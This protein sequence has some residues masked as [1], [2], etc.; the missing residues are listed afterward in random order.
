MSSVTRLFTALTPS[1]R[2]FQPESELRDAMK[3][4][5]AGGASAKPPARL[6]LL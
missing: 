4:V 2:T 1:T 5:A 3:S 6:G